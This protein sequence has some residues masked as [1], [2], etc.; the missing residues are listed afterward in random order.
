MT[1]TVLSNDNKVIFLV[2]DGLGDIPNPDH[3]HLT[4][5]EAAKKPNMDRLAVEK[6]KPR[7][8][9][10]GGHRRHAGQRAGPPRASSD[11]IHRA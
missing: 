1:G 3:S 5:L 2:F 10:P 9:Y 8:H 6:G 11:T 4:P 7:P